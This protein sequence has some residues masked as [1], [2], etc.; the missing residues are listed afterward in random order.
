MMLK[1]WSEGNETV[2]QSY[3]NRLVAQKISQDTVSKVEFSSELVL[4][5][6]IKLFFPALTFQFWNW[7]SAWKRLYNTK[8]ITFK[9]SMWFSNLQSLSKSILMGKFKCWLKITGINFF[10][11]SLEENLTSY[12]VWCIERFEFY[13]KWLFTNEIV[14]DPIQYKWN[15]FN[16]EYSWKFFSIWIK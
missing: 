6:E 8:I 14:I 12:V 9:N 1:T 3:F 5:N 7:N 16:K 15:C 10:N 4:R 2:V 13:K 11:T